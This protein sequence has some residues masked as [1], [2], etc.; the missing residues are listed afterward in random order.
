MKAV[1]INKYGGPEVLNIIEVEKPA[2]D[3][4]NILVEVKAS[5]VNPVDWKVAKGML[6]FIPGQ[7][8]P[9]RL[10]SDFAGVVAE[11]GSNISDFQIGDE[12]Y[13]V[14]SAIKGGAYANFVLAESHQLSIKPKNID[15]AD[16]ATIPLAALTA[17]QALTKIG[18]LK[19]GDTVCVNGSSGGVGHFA[20]Q[21]AKALGAKVVSVCSTKNIE[22]S[23]KFG[24]DEVVDYKTTDILETNHKFDIFFDSVANKSYFNVLKTLKRGGT[25]ITTLPSLSAILSPLFRLF[26]GKIGRMI[27]LKSNSEDLRFLSELIKSGKLKVNIDKKYPIEDIQ[28]AHRYSETGR[29][30][31][32][33]AIIIN[34]DAQ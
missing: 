16:A 23:K 34:E 2:V 17:Y 30:V 3:D 1:E 28:E 7:K 18:K 32:K 29:V 15:F 12:V 21:I 9:K 8:L 31:G 10:G 4:N 13:G 22:F 5:S 33:L 25:Y 19:E 24:S 6:K 20:V 27:N 11:V 26:N 14:I